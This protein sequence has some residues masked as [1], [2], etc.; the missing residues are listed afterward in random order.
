MG[1]KAEGSARFGRMGLIRQIDL[2]LSQD[3]AAK[4]PRLKFTTQAVL[5]L[6]GF[7]AT[8]TA[9]ATP[10]RWASR[11]P[12]HGGQD[13]QDK[14]DQLRPHKLLHRPGRC[15]FAVGSEADGWSEENADHHRRNPSQHCSD[16][17]GDDQDQIQIF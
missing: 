4:R 6:R 13:A 8:V 16:E 3:Q 17:N 7:A 11:Q 9:A 14:A 10:I 1:K 2:D 12:S 15:R 5:A